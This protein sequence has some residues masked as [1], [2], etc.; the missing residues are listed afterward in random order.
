MKAQKKLALHLADAGFYLD[1]FFKLELGSSKNLKSYG[2]G[3]LRRW[4]L[5]NMVVGHAA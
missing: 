4:L 3:S 1:V 2:S 5:G